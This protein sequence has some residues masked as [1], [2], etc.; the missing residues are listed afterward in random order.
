MENIA[1]E[2]NQVE[3][4][5]PDSITEEDIKEVELLI[6]DDVREAGGIL[7]SPRLASDHSFSIQFFNGNNGNEVIPKIKEKLYNVGLSK[8]S[9]NIENKLTRGLEND[10]VQ[11]FA[12]GNFQKLRVNPLS[13][14]CEVYL[15]KYECDAERIVESALNEKGVYDFEVIAI[16]KDENNE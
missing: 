4:V 9:I 7:L 10:L 15:K 3:Q 11:C 1:I 8:I 6:A 2:S 12:E 13:Q 14:V 5:E 16:I